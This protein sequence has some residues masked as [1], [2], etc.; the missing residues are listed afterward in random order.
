MATILFAVTHLLGAGHLTRAAAIGRAAVRAGH[1]V[2][3]VSGGRPNALVAAE[4]VEL[5][6]LP[7]VQ[8]AVD[9]LSTLRDPAGV[10]VDASY[11]A[12][13]RSILLETLARTRPDV[14]VTE[15]F[16]FGRRSLRAEFGALVEAAR[17]LHPRP[18]IVCSVRDV[19]V[20]PDRPEKVDQAHALVASLYDRVLVHGDPNLAPLHASWPVD[21]AIRA[22]LVYTGYVDA[23]DAGGA[24]GART[25]PGADILVSGGSS[26]ASL[27]LY[28]A[29]ID[30]ARLLPEQPWRILV[31][32]GVPEPAFEA[33]RGDAPAHV[34]VERAR[35]DFRALLAGCA[36]FVGQSGYNTATDLFAIGA[37]A[38][39][40]PFEAGRETEQR[41]R[42]EQLCAR[43][44][45]ALLPEHALHARSLAAAIRLA[46]ASPPPPGAAVDCDGAARTAA[47]LGALAARPDEP[48][49][50]P[51]AAT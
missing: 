26:A 5:V 50:R 24:A 44:L 39:L 4:G 32:H 38:V 1:R 15:H 23:D 8:G 21:S 14:V 2:V 40:V 36:A 43:G 7:P 20:A 19:L 13:R 10:P 3:L 41:I 27:P 31:G 47:I 17:A 46:L 11:L 12:R 22:R 18:V 37:R 49:E 29:A 51:G 42:A 35:P 28:R 16:P 9:D 25:A 45:A 33:L 34:A 30:A 48:D 6:Q